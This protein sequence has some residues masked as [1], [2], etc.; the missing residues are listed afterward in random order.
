MFFGAVPDRFTTAPATLRIDRFMSVAIQVGG[1]AIIF[2]V[3]RILLFIVW[4]TL[5]LFGGASVEEERF[6]SPVAAP[7]GRGKRHPRPARDR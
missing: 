6:V 1:V 7:S 3:F 2:A 5:P 4:Q